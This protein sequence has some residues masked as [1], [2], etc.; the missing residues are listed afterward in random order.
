VKLQL[1][2]PLSDDQFVLEQP[3]GA[4]V[5]HLDRPQASQVRVGDGEGK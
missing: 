2:Q 5:I 4:D 3:A 1:N